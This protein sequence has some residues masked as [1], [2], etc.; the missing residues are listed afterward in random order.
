MVLSEAARG[1]IH[2]HE[3]TSCDSSSAVL[4]HWWNT[5]T[6]GSADPWNVVTYDA[7]GMQATMEV[8]LY[9][10]FDA[11]S[12]VGRAVVVHSAA[13]GARIGCGILQ[14]TGNDASV[15]STEQYPGYG[16]STAVVEAGATVSAGEGGAVR[17]QPICF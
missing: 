12:H 3:G 13:S 8:A 14:L 15:A 1:G 5:A 11:G 10:G 17:S 16:G 7:S 4:G 9:D 2:V 6:L